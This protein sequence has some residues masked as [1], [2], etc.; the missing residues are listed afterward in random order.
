MGSVISHASRDDEEQL[1]E[2]F[3]HYGIREFIEKRISAYLSYANTIVAKDND[4]IV[5]T[6]QWCV[7]EDPNAGVAEFEEVHVL[8]ECRGKGIGS[9]LVER[10]IEE[11]KQY[12][13]KHSIRLRTIYLFI[14]ENNKE[15]RSLYEKFGFRFAAEIGD[16]FTDGETETLYVLKL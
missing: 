8:E 5:G 12:F 3:R 1:R 9:R 16:L 10:G 7:K 15:A 14:D 11:V 4:K 2:Y 6:L 13:K